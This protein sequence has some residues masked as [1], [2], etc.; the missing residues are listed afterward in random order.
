MAITKS[1]LDFLYD[2]DIDEGSIIWK[3]PSKNH[4]YLLGKEAGTTIYDTRTESGMRKPYRTLII[5][6]KAYKKGRLLFFYHHGRWPT[7]CVDH[8]NGNSL[9]DRITN[10]RS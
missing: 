5:D 9:D 8:I 7:P 3:N 4:P 6:G 2:I 1:K 10:L